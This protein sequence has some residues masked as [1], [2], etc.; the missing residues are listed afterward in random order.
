[1]RGGYTS[2]NTLPSSDRR[3]FLARAHI[4]AGGCRRAGLLATQGIRGGANRE[5]LKRIKETGNIFWA[6]SDHDW[7]QDGANVHVS[8]VAF[9][10][11][12]ET[13]RALDGVTV[14]IINANLTA[15]S[16]DLSET[17]AL[18][19]NANIAFMG[20]TPAGPFDISH[21]LAQ[22]WL[23]S[24]NPHGRPTSD[25]LRPYLN[26]AD[27]NQRSR[28]QWTVDATGLSLDQATLYAEPYGYLERNI[29]PV[30]AT[31]NRQ[32]YR[33]LWWI[34]AESRPAMRAAF[35]GKDRYLATCMVAKHRLFVWLDSVCVPANVVIVFARADNFFFGVLHSRTHEVWSLA[36]GSQLREKESGFRYTPT[37]CF[38]TFPLPV[39][40]EGQSQAIAAAASELNDLR[41]NWLNPPEWTRTEVM[42]F[43]GTVGGPWDRYIDPATVEDRRDFKVGTVRYPR[44]VPRDAECASRLKDRTL[45]KL[46][47][48]RPA[49]L[50]AC[51]ARLDAAVAAAYDWP[52]DLTDDAILERLLALNLERAGACRLPT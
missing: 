25:L 43:P 7:V 51:H 4:K 45:T 47:N 18:R 19:E 5:V 28:G 12:E 21:E 27:L 38:E 29:K 2:R 41:E 17:Q 13:G 42:E 35:A 37:T 23:C 26:G 3:C 22:N 33:D 49:W 44:I 40:T 10:V 46:Y 24:P 15:S 11:G 52:A 50:A 6:V 20:V 48:V 9:D 16:A 14:S 8:M 36:Q 31:N 30:R 34:Y 32:V 1:M 39:L